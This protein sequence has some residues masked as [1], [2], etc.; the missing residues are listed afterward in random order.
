MSARLHE[1]RLHRNSRVLDDLQRWLDAFLIDRQSLNVTTGTMRF[2]HDKIKLLVN[3]ANSH[4]IKSVSNFTPTLIREYLIELAVT[5][6]PGG[7]HM[8]YRCLKTFLNWYGREAEPVDWDNPIRNVRPPKISIHPLE[9]VELSVITKLLK[10]CDSATFHGARDTAI[11]YFL[12]DSGL[13]AAELC[14]LDIDDVDPIVGDVLV[15]NGKGGKPRTVMVGK[16]TR[17]AVRTY[18]RFRNDN[19]DALWV[20]EDGDRLTYWGLNLIL[21]RRAKQARVKKPGLHDFRRAFALSCLRSNM[22]V[23]SLQRL[24]GHA[25]LSVLRR[26]LDQNDDDS[27]AAH[28]KA[29]PVDNL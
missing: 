26:Y 6:N 13:R 16:R 5:H 10:V 21:K 2:Y 17:K 8:A 24:M 18:L 20:T 1:Q 15:R 11:I 28:A 25:D 14:A 29:S 9:P 27:R 19:E 12:L 23:F 7:V 22:D 4:G 3:Y